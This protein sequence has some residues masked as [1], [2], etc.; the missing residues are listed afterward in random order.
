LNK[1][2]TEKLL[3]SIQ[4]D[5]SSLKKRWF[6]KEP[7]DFLE[8]TIQHYLDFPK[9]QFDSGVRSG[10]EERGSVYRVKNVRIYVYL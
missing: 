1:I 6:F 3:N 5:E 7:M 10:V 8:N 4:G 2:S 9:S